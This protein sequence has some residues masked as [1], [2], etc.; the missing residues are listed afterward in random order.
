M[1]WAAHGPQ[2]VARTQEKSQTHYPLAP[3]RPVGC[4]RARG[5]APSSQGLL[6]F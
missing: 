6:I 1:S 5:R 3:C 2:A 4:G